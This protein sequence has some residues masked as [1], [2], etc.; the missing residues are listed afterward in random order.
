MDGRAAV[1]YNCTGVNEHGSRCGKLLF[2]FQPP[3]TEPI[4]GAG[5]KRPDLGAIE[6]KCRRC[7]TVN[8][9]RLADFDTSLRELQTG[10]QITPVGPGLNR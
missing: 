8:T 10:V 1:L 2:V 4:P 3:L 6:M 9:F 5:M 7:K